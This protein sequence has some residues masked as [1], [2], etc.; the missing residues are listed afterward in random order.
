MST[1]TKPKTVREGKA[2]VNSNIGKRFTDGK[3]TYEITGLTKDG[4]VSVKATDKHGKSSE[5]TLKLSG[6]LTNI[7]GTKKKNAVWSEV[8]TADSA[9]NSP[10]RTKTT[11]KTPKTEQKVPKTEIATWKDRAGNEHQ[12]E[13]FVKSDGSKINIGE[14]I[15]VSHSSGIPYK[16]KVVSIG[17]KNVVIK[18]QGGMGGEAELKFPRSEIVGK[19]DTSMGKIESK[20]EP[21]KDAKVEPKSESAPSITPAEAMKK[22][23]SLGAADVDT[24]SKAL[25]REERAGHT[26]RANMIRVL[27]DYKRGVGTT[28]NPHSDESIGGK[29]RASVE[30]AKPLDDPAFVAWAKKRGV[31]PTTQKRNEYDKAMADTLANRLSR[32]IKGVSVEWVGSIA[33]EEGGNLR[34]AKKRSRAGTVDQVVPENEREVFRKEFMRLKSDYEH[35]NDGNTPLSG[36]LFWNIPSF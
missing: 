23:G 2:F 21:K 7:F 20:T 32:W 19:R 35:N 34:A 27:R 22:L 31:A 3:K 6:T 9:K 14:E 11:A 15:I 12:V 28:S 13:G 26:E 4:E 29:Y 1:P 16:G 5:T 10:N 25:A 18:T 30:A 8:K 24:L 36:G 33:P 17:T